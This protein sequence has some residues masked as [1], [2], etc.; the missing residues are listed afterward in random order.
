[1]NEVNPIVARRLFTSEDRAFVAF[2]LYSSFTAVVIVPLL[3]MLLWGVADGWQPPDVIPS[4][5]T[6]RHWQAILDSGGIAVAVVRS[7][8]IACVVVVL[9]CILAF[10]TAWAMARF[11]FRLKRTLE[12]FIL[13][14]L[15]VPGIVVAVGL[16]KTFL[17]FG[18]AYSVAG[19]VLVQTVGTL[20]MM[21]RILS[22][23]LE[24]IPDDL[25]HAARTLGASKK[26]T[27]LHV[28]APLS[29]PGLLAG[30]LLSFIGSFEEFDKSFIVG[31]PVV[32]TLPIKLYIYLD[33]VSVQLPLAAIVALILLV[34]A[35]VVFVLAG[36]IM[37]D[38]LM[39]A[40]MGK[41]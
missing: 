12:V 34:P 39:A 24:G 40:G 19:V 14:P 13:A 3:L 25:I 16:G 38:D 7:L 5:Y 23:T 30:G 20:P 26:Q 21:I 29:A 6:L 36:R 1:M 27:F 41:V 10:P 35:I 37:R 32:Q 17:S 4:A 28:V 22:A 33:P 2:G 31:A 15:I 18:L 11:P 9:T 8:V